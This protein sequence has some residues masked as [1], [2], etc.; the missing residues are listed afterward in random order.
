MLADSI[1]S[2]WRRLRTNRISRRRR[3]IGLDHLGK[4]IGVS[5][6]IMQ[7][8]RLGRFRHVVFVSSLGPRRIVN[9][10]RPS[11]SRARRDTKATTL[12]RQEESFIN[13]LFQEGGIDANTFRSETLQ[14]RLPACLRS[15]HV[16]SIRDA[17]A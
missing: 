3:V 7:R 8:L 13:W 6:T 12:S 5:A 2:E 17:R 9:P 15:L 11:E 16:S 1:D 10:A 4:G 14:R